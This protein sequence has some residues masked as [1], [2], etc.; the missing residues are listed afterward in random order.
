MVA[1]SSQNSKAHA[2]TWKRG[3]SYWVQTEH[4]VARVL[5]VLDSKTQSLSGTLT[6]SLFAAFV[7]AHLV[8]LPCQLV[9]RCVRDEWD[10]RLPAPGGLFKSHCNFPVQAELRPD[11]QRIDIP[12][13]KER[14]QR[15]NRLRASGSKKAGRSFVG[16][17]MSTCPQRMQFLGSAGSSSIRTLPL[18][19][20]LGCAL[21]SDAHKF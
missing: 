2:E 17:C 5:R 16:Q 12:G 19:P 10:A 1:G 20:L 11:G 14:S 6:V 13:R 8:S 9:K 3:R 18:P 21:I 4:L 15:T 7:F